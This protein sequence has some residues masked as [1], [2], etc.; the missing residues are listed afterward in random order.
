MNHPDMNAMGMNVDFKV[1][2]SRFL[3]ALPP[4]I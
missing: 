1:Q 4:I 2:L 3:F